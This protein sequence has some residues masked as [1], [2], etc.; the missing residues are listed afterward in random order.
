MSV[1]K[2]Y[3]DPGG[4]NPNGTIDG[5]IESNGNDW[6]VVRNIGNNLSVLAD[7]N[8]LRASTSINKSNNFTQI[9]RS[10]YSFDLRTITGTILSAK[11]HRQYAATPTID[12]YGNVYI[13]EW[14]KA[15]DYGELSVQD[16]NNVQLGGYLYTYALN[17]LA[18]AGDQYDVVLDTQWIQDSLGLIIGMSDITEADFRESE[19]SRSMNDVVIH[20]SSEITAQYLELEIEDTGQITMMI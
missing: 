8:T 3:S 16:W 14:R 20:G 1:V 5:F 13:C 17:P 2:I 11:L 4:L 10:Y 7:S 9:L 18:V 12:L 15:G 6:N 19:P